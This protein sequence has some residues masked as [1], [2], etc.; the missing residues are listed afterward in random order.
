VAALEAELRR[1]LAGEVRF[2]AGSKAMYSTDASTSRQVPL[3][4]VT[5]TS[6]ADVI[7][8]VAA[9]RTFGAPVLS[10]GGGTSL[11][12][13]CCNVAL[14]LD[15]SKYLHNILEM[16]FEEKFARVEPGT[17]CD[18]VRHAAEPH[19]LTWG[20]DPA[21]HNR[22]TFGGMLGN[23]SC[24]V[25]SQMAGKAA[26]NTEEL[27]V[28]LYDGTVM[29][30]GWMT[31][32]EMEGLIQQGGRVGEIYAR[33]RSL[34]E[35]YRELIAQ[36]YPRIPR[37][38]SGYNLDQLLPDEH[39]RCNVARALVGSESTCV[40]ILEAKVKLIYSHPQRVL[41]VLGYPDV[42]RA[43]DH[44]LEIG[45]YQPIGLEGLDSRLVGNVRK[46]GGPHRQ[47]LPLL[48]EG[49]GWL[50][51]E[52]GCETREEAIDQAQRLTEALKARGNPPSMKL[53]VEKEDQ[54]KI[55]Q[56]R[57]SGLGA[58]A[59]VP[60]ERDTWPGWEDSAV[61]PEKLGG[62]LRDL[63]QLYD[64]YDYH[65]ALYGHFG[66]ACIHCRVDFD[67]TS[68]EGIRKWR[69]FMEEA[70]D[71][72][73]QY[74]GSLSGEHGDGQAR[75]E[76]LHKMFGEELIGAFREFKSIWDPDWKMNP[77][78]VVEPYR[79]DENLR[80]GADYRPWEPT[81]HFHYPQDHGSFA[82]AALRCVGVGKCR[83]TK[84]EGEED[85]MC[86]SFMVTREER[87]TTRGRAHI[88][89]EMLQG[90][91]IRNG[92][93]DQAVKE[94]LDLCLSCKGCKGD[95]PVNVDMATYKAEFLSHYWEGRLRPRHAYAFGLIDRWARMAS[96]APGF[97]NL[98]TQLP[99]LREVAKK[100]AGMP[101]ERSIPA[102]APETFKAWFRRRGPRNFNA[103]KVLLWPDTFNNFFSPEAAKAAVEVLESAGFQVHVPMQHLC[104]GRP[105]YDY[106]FLDRAKKYLLTILN[107][108][109]P[110]IAAGTPMVVLEP[111]CCSV[112]R[113]ELNGLMPDSERGH[114]LMENTFTL[115]EFL[116]KKANGYQ[117][118]R[119]QRQAVVQGHCHH[120]AIMRLNE[121]KAILRKMGL[122]FQLLESGCCGMAGSFGFEEDK[123]EVSIACGE[124]VLLPAVRK[125]DLSSLII[126]DGFSCKEQIAQGT[127]R[128]ALHLAEVMQIAL[129]HP[130]HGGRE[131]YPE[132]ELERPRREA[133]RRSMQRAGAATLGA[134]AAAGLLWWALKKR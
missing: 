66:Q 111:S 106:G 104:C 59:F 11:A 62:Y 112:F 65:P 12:G 88:L 92:W 77:G 114:R 89:W 116:E 71:L 107:A 122:D 17:I 39:G 75:A 76:F 72:C 16:N 23:N 113:D 13:Q 8:A 120:K 55:W 60:G 41:L 4:V 51:V 93:R 36:R 38:V 102:F 134:L 50:M 73:V 125:A 6:K 61:A 7:Q 18:H 80:L 127:P 32:R 63:R 30:V 24:G 133:Q 78:K 44:I 118:P 56:I 21:T 43:A 70:T 29:N 10:R 123:Y 20:P 95:C 58:S 68:T 105:L 101:A 35:R 3:G 49:G 132:E 124:R 64:K 22:C 82:H 9:G 15:W 67:L 85:A 126:A 98:F 5:P 83:R 86:P 129:H 96:L 28:L 97:V 52:F 37:R 110:E 26:D 69:S 91:V 34:R 25:H 81:T 53:F 31:D 121:E 103:P 1:N 27:Q 119:L 87:H 115:A 99:V 130:A 108:L 2:D 84:G 117:P 54:G 131:V 14:V 79:M 128:H 40:T 33:L 74:G 90:D 47:Y 100:V 46:K 42:Y 109:E 19:K 48:P 57:E 45:E 94:A